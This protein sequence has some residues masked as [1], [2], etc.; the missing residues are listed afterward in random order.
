MKVK[1]VLSDVI[2]INL[3]A[4]T[5]HPQPQIPSLGFAARAPVT[6][7][8]VSIVY[9]VDPS[10]RYKVVGSPRRESITSFYRSSNQLFLYYLYCK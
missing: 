4:L 1:M 6:R 7:T 2:R 9:Y 8:V 10:T 3:P 5:S